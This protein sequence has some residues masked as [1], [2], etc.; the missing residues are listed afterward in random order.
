MER[1]G[2]GQR[3]SKTLILYSSPPFILSLCMLT[4][5]NTYTA[6][7]YVPFHKLADANKLVVESGGWSQDSCRAPLPP[8]PLVSLSLFRIWLHVA[9]WNL[10][11]HLLAQLCTKLELF[12]QI[13]Y[14]H[15]ALI[16]SHVRYTQC[17][18]SHVCVP[19]SKQFSPFL[20][21]T[22]LVCS[23]PL[24]LY[25]GAISTADLWPLLVA[26][27]PC[28]PPPS[29]M[30]IFFTALGAPTG[31]NGYLGLNKKVFESLILK[32]TI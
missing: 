4:Y 31:E 24:V 1:K 10:C 7:P 16:C 20:C 12:M 13:Q 19:K 23:L 18:V 8:P 22:R 15:L 9:P 25:T 11:I 32:P 26:H 27:S 17:F 6:W 3:G 21:L 2:A 14:A 5:T 30:Y 28:R 29:H